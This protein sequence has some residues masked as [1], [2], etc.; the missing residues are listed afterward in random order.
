MLS[1][2]E[3]KVW[4]DIERRY[5]ADVEEPDWADIRPPRPRTGHSRDIEELPGPLVAGLWITIV[6]ILFGASP[7][8]LATG[9]LTVVG[10]LLWRYRPATADGDAASRLPTTSEI[11]ASAGRRT[12]RRGLD[13][14]F[15]GPDSAWSGRDL[16]LAAALDPAR[17]SGPL[18]RE[19]R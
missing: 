7:A 15:R 8:A 6:L 16:P 17:W 3:Q 2:H 13:I 12:R 18:D 4:D 11:P 1:D 9:S 19:R 14:T 10:W 5:A